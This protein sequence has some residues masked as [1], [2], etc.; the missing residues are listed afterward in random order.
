MTFENAKVGDKVFDIL[1]REWGT[2]TF[3]SQ[4]E[5]FV[6]R[7]RFKDEMYAYTSEGKY[8]EEH[9]APQLY[10]YEPPIPEVRPM[11]QPEID[12]SKVPAGTEVTVDETERLFLWYSKKDSQIL[13]LS[14]AEYTYWT[15]PKEV[16]IKG[17]VKRKWLKSDG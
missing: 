1:L 15:S 6:L 14:S 16:T 10:T 2:V 9:E 11:P 4:T 3:N 17:K 5:P 13:T 7:V 8:Y 12:W